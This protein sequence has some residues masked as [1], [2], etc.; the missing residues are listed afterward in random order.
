MPVNTCEKFED[1]E[2]SVLYLSD[3]NITLQKRLNETNLTCQK[4]TEK[5]L[6]LGMYV[7]MFDCM[8]VF[9]NWDFSREE[10]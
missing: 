10:T 8:I 6:L 3:Q 5:V 4:L 2:K 9:L 1:F 7:M